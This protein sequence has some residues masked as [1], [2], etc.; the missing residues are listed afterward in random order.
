MKKV[1]FFTEIDGS[2]IGEVG[3]KGANLGELSNAGFS[4]PPGFCITTSAYQDVI[5]TSTEMEAF[6]EECTAVDPNNLEQLHAI[7]ARIRQHIQQL[8]IPKKLND[9]IIAAWR[10]I[11]SDY[12]YAVRSSATAEDLPTASFAGQQDTYLHVRGEEALLES[13]RKCWASLFTDRAIAYR[14]KNGFDHRQVWLS[15]IVQRMILPEVSGIL[16]TADPINGNRAV[17]SI[18]ASFGL[19]EA[20]VSGVVTADL[21]KVKH[22]QILSKQI[23]T[24]KVMIV[25]TETGGTVQQ[26]IPEEKQ[27]QQALTDE[28][29][30]TLAKL[31]KQIEDHFGS[32]QDIEFCVQQGEIFVVQSRP[33]TTL[34]PMPKVASQPLR[35]FISFG[36]IQMMTEPMKPLGMSVIRTIFPFGKEEQSESRYMHTAG[37]R[38]FIDPSDLLRFPLARKIVPKIAANMDQ[39]IC[40]ALQEVVA[41]PSFSQVAPPKGLGKEV[42]K[43][44]LPIINKVYKNMLFHD[45]TTAKNHVET[46]MHKQLSYWE[47]QLQNKTGLEQLEKMHALLSQSLLSVVQNL[48]PY[49][50]PFILAAHLLRTYLS[51]WVNDETALQKLSQS[52][53]GNVSSEMGLEIGDLADELRALP[54]VVEYLSIADDE[55]FFTGL[56]NVAGG[57]QFQQSFSAFLAKYGHRCPGEIDITNPR[58]SE[59][60]TLL[61]PAILGHMRSVK[62]GEHRQKFQQGAKEAKQME[63]QIYRKLKGHPIRYRMIKRLIAIYRHY[64]ALREHHKYFLVRLLELCKKVIMRQADDWVR[65]GR[66]TEREDIFYLTMPEIMQLARNENAIEL[67]QTLA[68]RKS[69]YHQHFTLTPPRVMT[70]EG[71]VVTPT[72]DRG[73]FPKGALIGT[74]VS[75]GVVEG[76]ARI[77][78][79]PEESQLQEGEILVAPFTDPGW[80]PLFQSAVGLVT[81][82]GGLMTHGSVVAREYGIPAVVGVTD[83]LKKIQDGQ[84]IRI[85]GTQGYVEIVTDTKP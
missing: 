22:N 55:T 59:C 30:L 84:R 75:A 4:V 33:I 62:P 61:V 16:F 50:A 38:L 42:R 78:R 82:V 56:Q 20:L 19:G 6:L 35:V 17:T 24:K 57:K 81:E 83:A 60:P 64:G 79:S 70:S 12:S 69:D 9:E 18:D 31:G 46:Y 58:W 34:Y 10:S 7:G 74:P 76:R 14:I 72:V 80:T 63:E 41:R 25:P 77:V 48:V 13:I 40:L 26:V 32:P 68:T 2:R 73:D 39:Q 3:G 49:V 1:M 54:D 67:E 29:I 71:E 23:A 21:Y 28:Q 27:S 47:E 37:S 45:P 51:R 5:A 8:A 44:I 36:H 11:G 85:D 53:K 66:L 65:E 52:F 15:V 43:N